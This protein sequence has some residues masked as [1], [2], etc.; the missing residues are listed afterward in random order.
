MSDVI[1]FNCRSVV[2]H[3]KNCANCAALLPD[4]VRAAASRVSLPFQMD[5]HLHRVIALVQE[6]GVRKLASSSAGENEMSVIARVT[7]VEAFKSLRG[8][9]VVTVINPAPGAVDWIVTARIPIDNNLI[10]ETRQYPFVQSLKA[11]RRLS[12]CL[13]KT[14]EETLATKAL[15]PAGNLAQGGK[16]VIVGIVD[17][18]MDFAHKN[19]RNTDGTTRILA[20][21]D[22]RQDANPRSP[23]RFGY[24]I[25]HRKA[26][27]D[28]ALLEAP[29]PYEALQYTPSENSSLQLGA[30]ATAVADV[31]AGNG[32]GTSCAGIAPQADIVF[33]E[34]STKEIPAQ[35]SAVLDSSFGG[36]RQLLEAIQYIFDFAS[37]RP[38]VI[39]ISLATNGGPHDGSSLVELG[40]D[41]LVSDAPNRAVVIAAGNSAGRNVHASGRV[42][43]GGKVRLKWRIPPEDPSSNELEVWFSGKDRLTL[44][45]IDPQKVSQMTVEPGRFDV[46]KVGGGVISAHNRLNDPN[47][48]EN[49]IDIFFDGNVPD[50]DWT[51]ELHGDSVEDGGAFHAWI[52]RDEIRQSQFAPANGESYEVND[53]C[54]LGSISCGQKTIVVGAYDAH[55]DGKPLFKNSGSGKTRDG[56]SKPEVSAPGTQVLVADSREISRNRQTGTSLSA[57]AVA[58]IIALMLAEAK[59]R[60][61]S[62]TAD[63]I[64]SLLIKAARKNPP[65]TKA[66]ATHGW[67]PQYGYG[68][69]SA[70]DAVAGVIEIVKGKGPLGRR[71]YSRGKSA[72]SHSES[73]SVLIHRG[74]LSKRI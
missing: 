34:L 67:D 26:D 36:T 54:T 51:I 39:N 70:A 23:S 14:C 21:W 29:D 62:L 38:C 15:L 6:Q 53:D 20:L 57:P 32:L 50:G 8:V 18:G 1:C 31:A 4:F 19:F 48:G 52:E 28:R 66:T 46:A 5:P 3:W 35:S 44:D 37:D 71:R 2:P 24:G 49:T 16:G 64:K 45:V 42:A 13:E 47:N 12:P 9:K 25:E 60:G 11:S 65:S 61:I 74:R 22:Q 72:G 63:Q 30:H 73:N 55:Q 68:R 27:I 43:D 58:G 10:E 17:F 33:V 40:I 69:V 56:R 7:D 59:A 41:Q